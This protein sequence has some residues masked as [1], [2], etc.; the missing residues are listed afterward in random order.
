[1]AN[2]LLQKALQINKERKPNAEN[3]SKIKVNVVGLVMSV[4]VE[5]KMF[6]LLT[7]TVIILAFFNICAQYK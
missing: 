1:M 6:I 3:K 4:D 5:P 7:T 2:S